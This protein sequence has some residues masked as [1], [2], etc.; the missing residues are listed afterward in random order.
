MK[1]VATIFKIIIVLI[2][3]LFLYRE[4]IFA[5]LRFPW[6][7]NISWQWMTR[8]GV[9]IWHYGSG[10]CSSSTKC[11]IDIG[12]NSDYKEL[13]A[14]ESGS[15]TKVCFSS[16]TADITIDHN[17]TSFTYR[18][19][20]RSSLEASISEGN[21]ILQGQLLGKIKTG[22]FDE[23]TICNYLVTAS[24]QDTW[25]HV[26]FEMPKSATY[27]LDGWSLT[28]PNTYMTKD[29][30]TKYAGEYFTSSNPMVISNETINNGSTYTTKDIMI[31]KDP[32]TI[33]PSGGTV[34]FKTL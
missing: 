3:Y 24:Q 10:N 23:Q 12:T 6:G 14:I 5:D 4:N 1:R 31:I 26:H 33:S 11:A 9:N 16:S 28:Y 34:T 19:V 13:L 7:Q 30:I 18:H 15:V 27:V 25:G 20:E 32:V 2:C 29:G 8:G 17:G 22:S 21:S